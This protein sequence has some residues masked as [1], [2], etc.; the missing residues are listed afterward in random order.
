LPARALA[1]SVFVC[2]M[3]T[4]FDNFLKALSWLMG[5][6]ITHYTRSL[7]EELLIGTLAQHGLSQI[8]IDMLRSDLR[9]KK[10]RPAR[11]PKNATPEPPPVESQT[12]TES[13][14]PAANEVSSSNKGGDDDLLRE[15]DI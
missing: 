4:V 10:I 6:M 7:S 3:Y 12:N 5:C 2:Q 11:A 14:T 13:A 15:F 1:N 9:P 8:M